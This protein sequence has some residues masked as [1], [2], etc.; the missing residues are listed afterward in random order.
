MNEGFL[1]LR[2]TYA[3]C[4]TFTTVAAPVGAFNVFCGCVMLTVPV[5]LHIEVE[6]SKER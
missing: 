1:E 4:V 5:S 2:N 6:L 3:P